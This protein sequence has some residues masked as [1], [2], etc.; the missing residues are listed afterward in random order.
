MVTKPY[1]ANKSR[2]L[3]LLQYLHEN[4]DDEHTIS[5]ND[6]IALLEQNGF[7]A[8]RH[9][10]R[11]D[12]AALGNAGFE[13]IV[14]REGKTN[15][16]R[17]GRRKFELPELRMMVDAVASSHFISKSKS[18]ELIGKLS[19]L[20]SKHLTYQLAP[21][22]YTS[23]RIKTDSER[24]YF[25]MD[26][27]CRAI[28]ERKKI[29]FQYFDYA[30]PSKK[31]VLRHGGENYVNSPYALIWDADRYY[32]VGYSDK[33]QKIVSSR[34]DRMTVPEILDDEA[35]VDDTFNLADYI[36]KTVRMYTGEE[37]RVTL[38]CDNALMKNVIDKFGLEIP[39]EKDTD[40]TF[41]TKITVQTSP[42]FYSWVFEYMGGIQIISPESVKNK[43]LSMV[44]Q[45]AKIHEPARYARKIYLKEKD[46]ER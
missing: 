19:S 27:I 23:N 3:F 34:I 20:T 6:L 7:Q 33:H 31:K 17:F 38:R 43:Y 15:T 26:T 12:M 35:V 37:E 18:E 25:I 8:N 32:L 24:I 21:R 39:T 2:I 10:L 16:Y 5:T 14:A 9:T 28:D 30:A 22:I 29:I 46:D 44:N 40:E 41:L 45:A 11:S 42:P 1:I 36:S 13:I 4:T